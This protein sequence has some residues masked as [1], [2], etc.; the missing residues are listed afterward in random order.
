MQT[1]FQIGKKREKTQKQRNMVE[2]VTK[3]TEEYN[4]YK[5]A[6]MEN[7]TFILVTSL[8]THI[9]AYHRRWFGVLK[10]LKMLAVVWNITSYSVVSGYK[11]SEGDTAAI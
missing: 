1:Q 2:R 6:C 4:I 8:V 3:D 10:A 5:N 7:I 11:L 9:C